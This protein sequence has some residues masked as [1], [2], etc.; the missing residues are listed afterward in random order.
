MINNELLNRISVNP[1]ICAG[2]P[3]I[4]GTRIWVS[5][6]GDYSVLGASVENILAEYPQLEREDIL[7]C[8]AYEKAVQDF[9]QII[10]LF[11]WTDAEDNNRVLEQAINTLATSNVH[12]IYS[13]SDI[14]ADKLFSLDARVYAENIGDDAYFPNK[15]FSV[16][17]FLYARCCVIANGEKAY[18][19]VL[20]SPNLMPKNLTFESLLSLASKAY[21]KK[22]GKRFDYVATTPIE[23]YSNNA[24]W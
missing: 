5:L 24:G 15:Y 3:R 6:I 17:N 10:S 19:N 13:F 1:N 22:T 9:W 2:E 4:K 21:F 20:K 18:H 12:D 23:T 11:D 7:A 14:L 16:D 8:L